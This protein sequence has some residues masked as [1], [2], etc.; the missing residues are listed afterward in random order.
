MKGLET[1]AC[2]KGLKELRMFTLE[3]TRFK[4]KHDSILKTPK[5]TISCKM[6]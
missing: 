5:R 2:L 3:K 6:D 4:R 1:T